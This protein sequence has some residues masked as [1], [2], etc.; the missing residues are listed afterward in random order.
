M[1]N[2]ESKKRAI[3]YLRVSTTEQVHTDFDADGYSIR[4]QR[5]ACRRIADQLGANVIDEY[6]DRGESAKSAARPAL[7]EMLRRLRAEADVDYVIVHKVDRLARSREDDISIAIAIRKAGAQLVS[8]TE[9]IDE[10]PQGKLLHG[11]M[12]T[13]AEFY[14]ANLATESRKGMLQKAKSGGTPYVAPLGYLNVPERVNGKEIRTIA[15][16]PERAP[17]I[18]WA[19][20]MYATGN[21]AMSE[22]TNVL[23][24]R[25]LH[26]R[27]SRG[28]SESPINKSHVEL[29]LKNPY[30]TGVVVYEG[31]EYP[32]RHEPLITRELFEHVQAIRESRAKSREKIHKHPHYLKGSL[33]CGHCGSRLG[34]TNCKGNGGLYPYFYCLGRQKKRTCTLRHTLISEIETRVEDLWR[35]IQY[36]PDQIDRLHQAV[37]RDLES[38]CRLSEDERQRQEKRLT[39]LAKQRAK[40]KDAY[41]ADAMALDD[42]RSEQ[43][44]IT[45]EEEAAKKIIRR[46]QMEYG[47]LLTCAEDALTL[48]ADA[49]RLYLEAPPA[50]RRMLNQ[51][52]FES[53]TV[54]T[55]DGLHTTATLT[56]PFAVL[57]SSGQGVTTETQQPDEP[58]AATDLL[59]E[60]PIYF[61]RE[62]S[63]T[64]LL[65]EADRSALGSDLVHLGPNTKNRAHL[66]GR[67][68]KLA[69][70]APATGLEPV[71]CRLT[72]GRS[73]D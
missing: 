29:I 40:A 52:A 49:H 22:I 26:T 39:K 66:G 16:D 15:V 5:E 41:Y 53:L 36:S 34:I 47:E 12:A 42:F 17:H 4:A 13:I 57:L 38:V 18:R 46:C 1:P 62:P 65:D 31:V 33:V 24:D 6:V 14:S 50:I 30:Y 61:R 23:N 63:L 9:N 68:S 58:A 10:T 25:G 43:Q 69:S 67:G 73:A 32:G 20:E 21:W 2:Q 72:A 27:A 56:Q 35:D 60:G 3:I 59:D 8:A 64:E 55:E 45:R 51:A 11:I 7:Q 71:T 44:R 54:Y 28:H 19:F 37:M 70:V 48:C